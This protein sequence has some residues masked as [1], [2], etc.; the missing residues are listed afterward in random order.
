[1]K[2]SHTHAIA[3]ARSGHFATVTSY[4]EMEEAVEAY[5]NAGTNVED[6][7]YAH[8]SGAAFEVYCEFWLRSFGVKANSKLGI[9][10]SKET[11]RIKYQVGYDFTYSGL[12][13]ERG[14]IQTKFRSNPTYQFK[15]DEFGSL[16]LVAKKEK[17]SDEKVKIFTNLTHK[18]LPGSHG[19]YH[20]TVGF[21][22]W[23]VLGK[24]EQE[25]FITSGFWDDFRDA[26]KETLKAPSLATAPTMRPYQQNMYTETLKVM[27][28]S[29]ERARFIMATGGGKTL[30]EYNVLRHGFQEGLKLQVIVAPTIALLSQHHVG[31]E[32]WSMFDRVGDNVVPIHFRTGADSREEVMACEDYEQTTNAAEFHSFVT[33]KHKDRNVLVFL[34]YASADNFFAGL[35][36]M[37]LT[38]D[39]VVWDEF[40]HTVKQ[41]QD[42]KAQFKAL[43]VKR[44]LF[45]SASQKRGKV[46][47][48][49]FS[50]L[51]GPLLSNV[52]YSFLREE[53][54]LVPKVIIKPIVIGKKRTKAFDDG[55]K[56]IA[57]REGFDLK[58]LTTEA[59]ALL[60]AR[61]D[62]LNSTNACN[63]LGFSK[64]VPICKAICR[65]EVMRSFLDPHTLLQTVHAEISGDERVKIFESV[66]TSTDSLLPQHSVAKEGIDI[67]A[68]TGVVFSREMEVIGTQQALGR[69]VRAHPDDTANLKAGKISLDSPVGWVKP[70]AYVYVIMHADDMMKD[71]K[72]YLQDIIRK[73]QGA[74][75]TMKD[76]QFAEI[77]EERTGVILDEMGWVEPPVVPEDMLDVDNLDGYAKKLYVEM[78]KEEEMNEARAEARE[79]LADLSVRELLSM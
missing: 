77:Q 29:L 7:D 45:F 26:L 15:A 37:K 55:M 23:L 42:Y 78:E 46:M 22:P 47:S 39:T 3:V 52:T 51:F 72:K 18:P 69:V 17:V 21:E 19:I 76:W 75:L 40:H 68:F 4:Q 79:K 35:K 8:R 38:V 63:L 50:K 12:K 6:D 10:D 20:H 5:A 36:S 11:S 62:M 74:G 24:V 73:L 54:V 2:L 13:G 32:R 61:R 70:V 31:F 64:S 67:T 59:A 66:K 28:G 60:V 1:M 58:I 65:S 30:V 71:F 16:A 53:G 9:T 44:N 33:E 49:F 48:S 41:K 25:F 14:L 27:D 57:E 43:P 56:A 34:T